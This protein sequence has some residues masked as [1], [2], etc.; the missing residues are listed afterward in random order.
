MK[1]Y[2]IS[3]AKQ[4]SKTVRSWR[5]KRQSVELKKLIRKSS[6]SFLLVF[7]FVRTRG[8]QDCIWIS[9]LFAPI[10]SACQLFDDF[11]VEASLVLWSP[12][13]NEVR[14]SLTDLGLWL[15]N[16]WILGFI[17]YLSN[18][19]IVILR[20]LRRSWIWCEDLT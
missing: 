6:I 17:E 3:K 13:A 11:T 1:I 2:K 19:H 7:V 16:Y 15:G 12:V 18:F 8:A 20:S 5:S 9:L 10:S 4:A 14:V